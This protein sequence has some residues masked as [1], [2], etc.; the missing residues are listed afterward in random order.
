M[1]CA[2]SNANES[3]W[4]TFRPSTRNSPSR[5]IFHIVEGTPVR[6]DME[7]Q[8]ER[9]QGTTVLEWHRWPRRLPR[10]A[11]R[12]AAFWTPTSIC[13]VLN[14]KLTQPVLI[15]SSTVSFLRD[16][17]PTVFPS[18]EGAPAKDTTTLSEDESHATRKRH[19]SCTAELV[20]EHLPD[21]QTTIARYHLLELQKITASYLDR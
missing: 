6:S 15:K 14:P 3:W 10:C 16:R 12:S 4:L 5:G 13:C 1:A 18:I 11:G 7:H 8:S 17:L 21:A 19:Y 9:S 20:T 2:Q